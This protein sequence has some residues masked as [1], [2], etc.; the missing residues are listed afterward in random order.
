MVGITTLSKD[1]VV[2]VEDGNAVFNVEGALPDGGVNEKL[3]TWQLQNGLLRV[4]V[5]V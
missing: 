3:S 2:G 5:Q 1:L 4:Q